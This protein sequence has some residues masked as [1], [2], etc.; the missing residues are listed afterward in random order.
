MTM[1]L[2]IVFTLLIQLAL[3]LNEAASMKLL[4]Y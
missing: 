2:F 4:L 1:F 3:C